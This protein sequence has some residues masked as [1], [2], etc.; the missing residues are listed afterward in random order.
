MMEEEYD[1]IDEEKETA[2]EEE[3]EMSFLDHLEELRWHIV[4]SFSVII[5]LAIVIFFYKE[6]VF[7]EII[8]APTNTGFWTFRMLCELGTA[9][10]IEALCFEDFPFELQSRQMM[11][12]FMMSIT[13]AIVGGIIISFPYLFFEVWRFVSPGLYAN[14]RKISRGAVFFVSVLFLIGISFGYFIM[15]PIAVNFFAN[16]SVSEAVVNQFDITNYVTTTV[17]LVFGSGTLFQLPIVTYFLAKI[18]LITPALMKQYRKHAIV[19]IFILGAMITPPDP[20]TQIF[21]A[22]PL[23]LLYQLSIMICRSVVRKQEKQAKLDA[24]QETN[25]NE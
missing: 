4:R 15:T 2:P 8:F 11:G 17:I 14:E 1:N 9:I 5:I 18:G 25:N 10:N 19:V 20:F 13:V 3:K 21:I 6:F 16:Y 24:L 12:Q 22:L 7:N 23:I